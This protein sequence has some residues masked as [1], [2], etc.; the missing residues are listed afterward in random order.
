MARAIEMQS[1][2]FRL[3]IERVVLT[4]VAPGADELEIS[5]WR[6]TDGFETSPSQLT[7]FTLW[8]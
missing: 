8:P 4:K 1:H 3:D 5:A 2:R 6:S 7:C